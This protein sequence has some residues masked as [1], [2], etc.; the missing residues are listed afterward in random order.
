MMEN[1]GSYR[2]ERWVIQAWMAVNPSK[3]KWC[4]IAA[5]AVVGWRDVIAKFPNARDHRGILGDGLSW[6]RKSDALAAFFLLLEHEQKYKLRLIH[7]LDVRAEA[8]LMT[9]GSADY[10]KPGEAYIEIKSGP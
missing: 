10:S 5:A 4:D 9:V 2:T 6:D 7:R 1:D 8:V 3:P